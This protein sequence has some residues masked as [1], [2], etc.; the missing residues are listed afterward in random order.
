MVVDAL[1]IERLKGSEGDAR[2]AFDAM[3]EQLR[4]FLGRYLASR[5]WNAEA[6]EDAVSRTMVRVWQGRQ[7][8]RASDS[9]GF[10]A[11]VA[12]TASFCQR[13]IVHDPNVGRFAEEIPDFE[14]IPEPD[15]PYLQAL[16]I[17]SEEH[18]RLRRAA[19][20]LWLDA[21]QPSPEL[22][23]RILAAQL[24]YIHGTSWEE[25]VKI[26][27]PLS[28]D[29]L[30]EWL[31]DLGTINAFAF[32][33][34]YGDNESICAYLLGCKPEE[35]DRI[36]ENARNASSP[37][38]PGG[39]SQAEVRVIVWRYRNGL[40]S[41]Q[42]LRFSG[43]DFDK[44]QLEALFERC[45]AKL[46]FQAAACRLLDRL[47]PMAQEVARSGI[48]RRLAFQYATVDELPLKQIAE[49]TDP[50]TKALGASVTPGMLNVWL[51]GGRLY[52]QL[53]RFITEG[54]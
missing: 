53:A 18:D 48:W 23:R 29:M 21:T 5:V 34:V 47:G 12:R 40:A 36:T 8:V 22:E 17:A 14:E 31:A 13:E 42:I 51:S 24:F 33:E 46:P 44:E 26:V 54:R 32:S 30:D 41:D 50:A 27:G 20:E 3:S 7:N 15:R 16:A 2:E 37:D 49:R 10:W 52:S 1:A 43:C 6:R 45:R 35:L 25:I 9:L 11:F 38:G 39:W 28:R 4:S 19:D